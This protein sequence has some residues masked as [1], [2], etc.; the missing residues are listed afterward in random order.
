MVSGEIDAPAE[1]GNRVREHIGASFGLGEGREV[2][3]TVHTVKNPK[4]SLDGDGSFHAVG[5]DVHNS[6]WQVELR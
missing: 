5:H 2:Q 4:Y 1:P 3:W 6:S